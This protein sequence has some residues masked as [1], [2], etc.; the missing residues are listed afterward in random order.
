MLAAFGGKSVVTR[1]H[2]F[3]DVLGWAL[4]ACC[5]AFCGGFLHAGGALTMLDLN[6]IASAMAVAL[7]PGGAFGLAS[8]ACFLT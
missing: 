4:R 5:R 6:F 7:V 8:R 2:I 3:G 1:A